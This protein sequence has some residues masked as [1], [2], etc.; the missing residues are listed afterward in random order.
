[1]KQRKEVFRTEKNRELIADFKT[2]GQAYHVLMAKIKVPTMPVEIC[3][4]I[5]RVNVEDP[6]GYCDPDICGHVQDSAA[7]MSRR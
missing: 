3:P 7:E 5:L 6:D 1:M 2:L 4:D